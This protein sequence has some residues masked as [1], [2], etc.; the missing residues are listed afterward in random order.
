MNITATTPS[1]EQ[2]YAITHTEGPCLVLAGPGSGKTY[3]LT[4]RI[5]HLL[6]EQHV[7][8]RHILALTFTNKAAREMQNRIH[9]LAGEASRY[10][11]IG[12]FHSLFARMLR[13]EAEAIG[14]PRDFT[15]YD[16][17]DSK[18]LIKK[19]VKE[20]SLSS[21]LYKPNIVLYR[22][23][24][25]KNRLLVDAQGYA[26]HPACIQ[27]DK[28]SGRPHLATIFTHYQARCKRAGAMD[29]DDIL[30]YT[31]KLLYQHP[32]IAEK[33]QDRFR[34]VL[35]DE[36]Q[37]TNK[38]QYSLIKKLAKKHGNLCVI[39]DDAQSIYAFRGAEVEHMLYFK[40][41]FPRT[42]T[43]ELT[44]NFRSTQ[45]I[46]KAANDIIKHN[47]NQL[48]KTL[49]TKNSAGE[50]L[51]A[52]H[53]KTD[54][55]EAQYVAK[56]I[57][58]T[59]QRAQAGYDHFAILYRTNRQS[60]LMEE[61]LR[62][63]G[64]PYRIRGGTSFYNRKEVKDMLSYLRLLVNPNDEQAV[65]RV[66]NFPKRGIGP[67]TLAKVRAWAM[68]QDIPLWK[69]LC[70]SSAIVGTRLGKAIDS[71]TQLI[72]SYQAKLASE[73][74]YTLAKGLAAD[75]GLLKTL[76]DER[77]IEGLGRYENIQE[78]LSGIDTFV[79]EHP[80]EKESLS[81]YLQQVALMTGDEGE[82]D[83]PT[84]TLM[85]MHAAK[86]L[87]Y[88]YVYL[89]GIEEGIL[90]S[91][92]M[93]DS[94]KGREEERRLFYVGITRAKK[95]VIINYA[96]IRKVFEDYK[97]TVPS[98]FLKEINPTLLQHVQQVTPRSQ[99]SAQR[100]F[101]TPAPPRPSR[102]N[103]VPLKRRNFP[104]PTEKAANAPLTVGALVKHPAFGQGII[105]DIG[106]SAHGQRVQVNFQGT[107]MKTL[108][109]AYAPLSVIG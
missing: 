14:F 21:D 42:E 72:T 86:G 51:Q 82:S 100:S 13:I 103:L 44:H 39:G 107:G 64:I 33:Y 52:I 26:Q 2:H 94:A 29:F 63:I 31:H 16:T 7:D 101:S 40:K 96:T 106:T 6:Q 87:E 57:F 53:H 97:R 68:E 9:A 88:S 58:E 77:N 55:Q 56:S 89:T 5:A 62:K 66:I 99:Q 4:H 27:E 10:L 85:T 81:T 67:A 69:A 15:I 104:P 61:S 54:L 50:P 84:V 74:A 3:V 109:T 32:A 102:E 22:I 47:K 24:G 43:I 95:K 1:K 92:L 91:P 34:Y 65:D 23:S 45:H 35:V 19:I 20:L 30:L 83:L 79:Q 78:L 49:F 38:L 108:L 18:R 60:R 37:D 11:W 36:F 17:E 98:R 90:P 8:V 48:P 93:L 70:Q 75:S 71:F 80:E 105:T 12:T 28:E 59:S 46:V 76:H 41:D 25:A 73:D